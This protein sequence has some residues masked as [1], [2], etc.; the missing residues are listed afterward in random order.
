ME[1]IF[2]SNGLVTAV[3]D[4][5][6]FLV[7]RFHYYINLGYAVGENELKKHF[8]LSRLI[9]GF[10]IGRQVHHKNQNTLDNRKN[11]LI[12]VTRKEHGKLHRGKKPSGGLT[13]K[14]WS[15]KLIEEYYE[16]NNKDK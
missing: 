15:Q 4:E 7:N 8:S 12:V 13:Q 9:M 11:N 6:Y 14:E 16:Q 1:L 5:D 3:D 10:P 2:M